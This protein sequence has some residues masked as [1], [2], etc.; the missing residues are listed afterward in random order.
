M[1]FREKTAW[2]SFLTTL[3]IYGAY[4]VAFMRA[5]LL[6]GRSHGRD[7][8]VSFFACV[9]VLVIAQAILHIAAAAM[10]PAEARAPMDE[11]ERGVD[12]KATKIAFYTLQGAV[13]CAVVTLHLG[14]DKFIIVNAVMVALVVGELVRSGGQILMYR[15]VR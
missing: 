10:N 11:R 9:V 7:L 14:A 13:V 3:V 15:A 1:A 8:A 2:I 12:L 6:E 4:F 5:H